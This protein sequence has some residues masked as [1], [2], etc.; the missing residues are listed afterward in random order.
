MKCSAR[1]PIQKIEVRPYCSQ[2][3][4]GPGTTISTEK[5]AKTAAAPETDSMGSCGW[6]MLMDGNGSDWQPGGIAVMS[7]GRL[8]FTDIDNNWLR[9]S[10]APPTMKGIVVI[11]PP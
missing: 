9:L 4:K 11:P 5:L 2:M 8:L 6:S 1:N 3:V 10:A 7:D